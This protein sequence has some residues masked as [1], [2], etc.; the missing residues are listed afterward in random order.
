M[1]LD[2]KLSALL[3]GDL[4]P[5]ETAALRHR[6]D[7]E[8]DVASRWARMLELTA[9]LED[10]DLPEVPEELVA[11]ALSVSDV[12]RDAGGDAPTAGPGRIRTAMAVLSALAA[13]V[14]I[15]LGLAYRP[16]VPVVLDTRIDW[17]EVEGRATVLRD[18]ARIVVDGHAGV[19]DASAGGG[20]TVLE[21]TATVVP[22]GTRPVEL[23]PSQ[24]WQSS[25]DSVVLP[26]P[27]DAQCDSELAETQATL[28]RV[29]AELALVR[30]RL[31]THE[32]E[33]LAWPES[34]P[35]SLLPGM[36]E[37]VVREAVESG[38]PG[39]LLAVECS[40]YPCAVLFY[41]LHDGTV[42]RDWEGILQ[43]LADELGEPWAV[44]SAVRDV[45]KPDGTHTVAVLS[46]MDPVQAEAFEDRLTYRGRELIVTF[47]PDAM[48]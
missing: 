7:T 39:E 24:T 30:G 3:S 42:S 32:G 41:A 21:G 31:Y 40:E 22:H 38:A 10:L 48:R 25:A 23:A 4:P 14:L 8:P 12:R 27:V 5:A 35:P 36:F 33:P 19:T 26:T 17:M 34:L 6:I 47:Q 2:D 1:S 18:D 15:G 28:N 11:A 45:D 20:V 13:G 43:P 9:D 16:A 37:Q 46:I 29:E 44:V